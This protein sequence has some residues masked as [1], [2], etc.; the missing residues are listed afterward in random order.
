[1]GNGIDPASVP[2]RT[3]Y[4]GVKMPAIGIGTFGSDKYTADQVSDAL[5]GAVAGGYRLIDCASVYQN[6]HKIGKVIHRLI[7]D[8]IVNREEL[9][10]T[11]KVWNDMHGEGEVIASCKQSLKDLELEYLDL[12]FVHWPFPNYHAP[13]CD[14]D[15][16]NPDSK[17]FSVED[18]MEVWKQ[19]EQ[20]LDEGLVRHIGMS[21]M[22][23]PKLEAV[24][25]HCRIQP[26]AIEMELHPAFQQP[27]LFT[28]ATER[29][30]VP[31]GY[32]PIGSPSRPERDR[33]VE[34]VVDTQMIEIVEI[35]EAHKVHPVEVCL[36][37]A[38]QRGQVPI[39]FSVKEYQYLSNLRC[40]TED[41]LTEEE[42]ERIRLAD[43]NCR[44]VKGQVFLWPGAKSWE[45]LWDLDGTIT[46]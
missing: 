14:G 39:P 8:Q 5:Y 35:A 15:S 6:E 41:P 9:F 36:K 13:G 40:V 33:D 4:T 34:D 27:E 20:L 38:V 1:M 43:K 44:L 42:M 7:K 2:Q 21:N 18:F 31:I 46:Q 17:P 25:P 37:W 26:A 23:I 11:S 45:D 12:Y 29:Q 3:L 16:R 22:T 19:C 30:I 28:Y 32:C 24:L 10:I